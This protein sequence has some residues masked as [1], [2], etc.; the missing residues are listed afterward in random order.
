MGVLILLLC[1]FLVLDAAEA[2]LNVLVAGGTGGGKTLSAARNVLEATSEAAVI[3]DPHKESFGKTV[4]TH[5]SGNLLYAC[6]SDLEH[7]IGFELLVPS[8][9]P[10]P[11]VRHLENQ[12]RA[13]AFV[14]ILL[15]RRDTDGL[16]STPLLEEWCFAAI[17]LLL[18]QQAT[19][20][21]RLLPFAFL[22]GTD[23]FA[24]LV[25]GCTRPEV[26]A[27]FHALEK[28]SPRALRS[29]VGSAARLIN[30]A[31]GSPAFTAWSRGGFDLGK[32]LQDKGVLIVERG[33]VGEETMRAIM[34]AI[35]LL[36]VDHVRRRKSP[37]PVIRVYIDEATNARLVG[38]PE[39][40]GIAETRKYGLFWTFLV[41][42]LDFPGGPEGV[43]QNCL[44]HEWF[45]C[46]NY[47]LARKAA[48]DIAAGLHPGDEES[49]AQMIERLT[50]E[51]MNLK[52]GWRWV[53][54]PAG[55]RKDYVPLL[56]NPWV[57]W[58]GLREAKLKEKVCR[59]YARPEY[60]V[61]ATPPSSTSSGDTPQP[62]DSS[63]SSSAA[64]RWERARRKPTDGSANNESEDAFE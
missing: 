28:L 34:G 9:H 1:C 4:L 60:G 29:E 2:R 21:V 41:Q 63:S 39:L 19:Q 36:V 24:S 46:S 51:I 30:S 59:I 49:R 22:P 10:N 5:A 33:D 64:E 15:R 53:R 40:R 56:E 11:Q 14:Q 35:V 26:R 55:S 31:V 6:L 18:Y 42:N 48:T 3:L 23:E 27:K 50:A 37:F 16:A 8:T 43:L 7:A 38:S 32:F 54:D 62:S 12:Q 57:D 13:E 44:R 47:E 20:P 17:M 52:P 25:R 58:P 61:P 45:S